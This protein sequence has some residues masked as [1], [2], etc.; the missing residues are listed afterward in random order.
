MLRSVAFVG[1][2]LLLGLSG[3]ASVPQA[4]LMA[5][6]GGDAALFGQFQAYDGHTE[7]PL[8]LPEV[9]RRCARAD[10]VLFG[11]A[12]SDAVCNQLEAQLLAKLAAQRRALA[13]ALEFFET[14]TQAALDAYLQR[15][16]DEAAFRKQTRQGRAYVL[17]HRPL[18]ELC[19][20]A[21]IPVLAANAPRRLVRAYRM[22][23][24]NYADFRAGL[25]PNDQRWLPTESDFLA[26]P[27][28]ERFAEMM[29][30]HGEMPPASPLQ[31]TSGPATQPTTESATQPT[32]EPTTLPATT[33]AAPPEGEMP[34]AP[35]V[36]SMYRA[37]LLW[38]DTMSESLANYRA[39]YPSHRVMLIVGG[40]HVAHDGGTAQKF[41]QRRPGDRVV[42]V[43]YRSTTD[44]RFAFDVDDRDAGDIVIYGIAPPEE[45]ERP[46]M[47]PEPAAATQPTTAPSTTAPAEMPPLAPSA[48]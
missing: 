21:H 19:R 23:D 15:R 30:G 25:D 31:P 45:A 27:Y 16:I 4:R 43:I 37:Q 8:S 18:I 12:H 36:E 46:S 22:A 42:T 44:G 40:F 29:R 34:A 6:I 17:S 1:V 47:L 13:L 33:P 26:G 24:L 10:V 35:S 41:R 28:E 3:C 39:R 2:G 20:A 38:D 11:E 48:R 5:H 14:D 7:R 32:S 9:V